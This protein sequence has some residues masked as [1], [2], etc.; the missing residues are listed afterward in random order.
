MIWSSSGNAIGLIIYQLTVCS[1]IHVFVVSEVSSVVGVHQL[2]NQQ[3]LSGTCLPWFKKEKRSS[4]T[5]WTGT[6]LQAV[7]AH[8]ALWHTEAFV[9]LSQ[10]QDIYSNELLIEN[11]GHLTS[12][13]VMQR[14]WIAS[15]IILCSKDHHCCYVLCVLIAI[16]IFNFSVFMSI[17]KSLHELW[18]EDKA[19]E[20]DIFKYYCTIVVFELFQ[21]GF[22]HHRTLVYIESW[23]VLSLKGVMHRNI[24]ASIHC[25]YTVQVIILSWSMQH[26]TR[27]NLKFLLITPLV[28]DIIGESDGPSKFRE[29]I[30]ILGTSSLLYVLSSLQYLVDVWIS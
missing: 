25:V 3:K 9:T 18:G 1:L 12:P 14:L 30:N 26:Y 5:T 29:W 10:F 15:N 16:R 6:L 27:C 23:N 2:W 11:P 21:K 4:G 13:Y 28:E 7:Q 17:D 8:R 19:I 24:A 22:F 20:L